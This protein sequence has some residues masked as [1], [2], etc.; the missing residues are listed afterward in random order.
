MATA[1]P[2]AEVRKIIWRGDAVTETKTKM[3][4][5]L[6]DQTLPEELIRAV[7]VNLRDEG[8]YALSPSDFVHTHRD[9]IPPGAK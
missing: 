6:Y 7:L 3:G 5:I 2:E 1:D 8:V 4:Q 9:K